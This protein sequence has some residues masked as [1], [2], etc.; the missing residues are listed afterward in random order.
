MNT[1]KPAPWL[2]VT[3]EGAPAIVDGRACR[4]RAAFFEQ[5]ARVLEFPSYFGRNW[6]ALTDCL[7]DVG[8]VDV[9]VAH[10]EELLADEPA[11]QFAILL[12]VMA[13]AA[14][15]GLTLT[16]ATEPDQEGPLR[17][18]VAEALAAAS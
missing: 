2:T 3:T 16:L 6:D 8:K 11:E 14:A 10:A 4:T 12:D 15:D 9:F 18:R 13:T 7:R 5:A 1:M 17:R